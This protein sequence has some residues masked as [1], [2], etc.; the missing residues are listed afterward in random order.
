LEPGDNVLIVQGLTGVNY[1]CVREAELAWLYHL[2][3]K[4][5]V[6]VLVGSWFGQVCPAVFETYIVPV[7]NFG[8]KVYGDDW[9]LFSYLP[10]EDTTMAAWA[11][12]VKA[13]YTTDYYGTPAG[14]LRCMD[15]INDGN[16]I[17]VVIMVG[18]PYGI[19]TVWAPLYPDTRIINSYVIR[20]L[21]RDMANLQAGLIHGGVYDIK[22]GAQYETMLTEIGL[23]EH[24][25]LATSGMSAFNVGGVYMLTM[26][27]LGQ[28]AMIVRKVGG[29]E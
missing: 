26:L 28:I 14:D 27:I 25:E 22:G 9:A 24:N 8:D 15:N 1:G 19:T 7:A 17:D 3:S 20:N 5:G 12:D 10:G 18:P 13:L 16:D 4:P 21:V 29:E 11:E 6:K 23:T 2:F